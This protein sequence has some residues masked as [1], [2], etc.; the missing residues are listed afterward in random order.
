MT[1][2]P[3]LASAP[4]SRE[5]DSLP[6]TPARKDNIHRHLTE[7]GI[8]VLTFDRPD[9]TANIFDQATMAELAAHLD[10]I[11]S[12]DVRGLVLVSA[13]KS[14]FIA[15]ADLTAMARTRDPAQLAAMVETGQKV[16]NRIAALKIP[17]VAAIHGACVGG[18][19]RSAWPAITA[20]LRRIR[21]LRSVSRNLLGILPGLGRFDPPAALGRLA[22][23]ARHHPGRQNPRRQPRAE[24]RMI[25]EIALA[26]IWDPRLNSFSTRPPNFG[27]A[28]PRDGPSIPVSPPPHRLAGREQLLIKTRGH[29]PAPESP[30]SRHPRHTRAA[31]APWPWNAMLS[32]V[33]PHRCLRNLIRI[34][35]LQE[36]AKKLS[37]VPG[38]ER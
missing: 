8:C 18:G 22:Q 28:P 7:E 19:S 26:N 32:R 29:Y 35:F 36:R 34:F 10:Q 20:S 5:A 24:M 2:T 15:G 38:D 9:S 13:K 23:G 1:T 33:G 4:A 21:R 12:A 3:T 6:A 30:R 16:F 27:I 11:E 25:D 31:R 37:G 17:T 14:I